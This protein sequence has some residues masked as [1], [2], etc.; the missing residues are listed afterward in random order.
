MTAQDPAVTL[1]FDH[2]TLVSPQLPTA[3]QHPTWLRDPRTQVWRAPAHAYRRIVERW[4]GDKLPFTDEARRFAPVALPLQQ[5]I[6]PHPYQ[7][8]ALLAWTQAGQRG[9]VVL[10]T[11]AGKTVLA[12]LA[13]AAVGRPTLVVVPT[14]DLLTQWHGILSKHFGAPVG[15][16]GGGTHQRE[17]ITVATYDSAALHTEFLGQRFGLL[18][19]D[20]CHHLPAPSYQ[21]IAAGSLAPYRLGLTATLDRADGGEAVCYS[22]LGAL[23]FSRDA[24]SLEGTYLAPYDIRRVDVAMTEE[25][26]TTYRTERQ[27]YLDG[28]RRTGVNLSQP[29]GWGQFIMR[30]S[31]SPEG[32]RALQGYRAQRR[33]ALSCAGKVEALWELLLK[34]RHDRMIVFTDDNET[35]YRLSR[36]FLLPAITHRTKPEERLAILQGLAAGTY[37]AVL[38]SRVLNEGVDVPD[39][40]I[41]VVLSGSG[42]VREHV[43][44]LGRILRKRPDKRAILYEICSAATAEQGISERRRQHQ[45][46]QREPPPC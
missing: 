9:V 16:L 27:L 7:A 8:E 43:Q 30:A 4:H 13:M 25:E 38:T 37:V 11:G 34:H 20:E 42:S 6:T 45:V 32:R 12:L 10:P 46:Y 31:Q 29:Q 19:C 22:L 40:N 17:N 39:A 14:L 33:L 15:I 36:R 2:G 5:P 35:V 44:R 1:H 23:C 21:F 24:S 26:D 18:I 41:G 28:L 3:Y